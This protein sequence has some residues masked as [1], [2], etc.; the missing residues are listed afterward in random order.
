MRPKA[1]FRVKVTGGNPGRNACTVA[2]DLN[3]ASMA[4]VSESGCRTAPQAEVDGVEKALRSLPCPC[5]VEVR[6]CSTCLAARINGHVDSRI[7][8]A[9]MDG[10]HSVRAVWVPKDDS[11]N[12]RATAEAVHA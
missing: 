11:S 1:V 12:A 2:I 3:G 4:V 9:C 10:G 8:L 7:A 6:T 5:E